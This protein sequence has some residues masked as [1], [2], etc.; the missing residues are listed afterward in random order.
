MTG[1]VAL[2]LSRWGSLGK[3]QVCRGLV[4]VVFEFPG[5]HPDGD[6]MYAAPSTNN[7]FRGNSGPEM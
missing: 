7:E 3:D 6:V 1:L 5:K 4:H 2:P